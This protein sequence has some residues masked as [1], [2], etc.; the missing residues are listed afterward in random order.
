VIA[1][2]RSKDTIKLITVRTTAFPAAS[3]EGG[4]AAIEKS[5]IT[6]DALGEMNVQ[7][8]MIDRR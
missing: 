6:A 5:N 2:V 7:G 4:S 8:I 1:K 3:L